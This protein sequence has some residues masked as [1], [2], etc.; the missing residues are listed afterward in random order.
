[1]SD[2]TTRKAKPKPIYVGRVVVGHVREGVFY[3]TIDF[4][5]HVLLQP[6]ALA[7]AVDSLEQARK[8]GAKVVEVKDRGTGIVYRTS[9]TTLR[10]KGFMVKRGGYE[11]QLALV[12][13][14]WAKIFPGGGPQLDLFSE[15]ES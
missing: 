8:A 3:K 11:L 4:A 7:F 12:L 1:M 5:E 10:D 13:S 15:G 14:D 2:S 9:M 6:P